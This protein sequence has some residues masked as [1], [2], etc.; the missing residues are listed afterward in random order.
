MVRLSVSVGVVLVLAA[1]G[2]VPSAGDGREKPSGAPPAWSTELALEDR[3]VAAVAG[4]TLVVHDGST[5]RGLSLDGR[6]LWR[7]EV[8]ADSLLGIAGEHIVVHAP[9]EDGVRVI[10][11]G[12]GED[13]WRDSKAGDLAVFGDT[14]YSS[15]CAVGDTCRVT[16]REVSD[17]T[18]RWDVPAARQASVQ[19]DAV[20][21]PY[22]HVPPA[23]RRLALVTMPDGPSGDRWVTPVEA[24]TGKPLSRR[25]EFHTWHAFIAGDVMV[26]TDHDSEPDCGVAM[27]GYDVKTGDQRWS[28]LA[29]SARDTGGDC[30]KFLAPGESGMDAIGDGRT[31]V[32]VTRGGKPQL[33]DL[34]TGR[35]VWT[36]AEPGVPIS[37]QGRF[38]LARDT[39]D[40]GPLRPYDTDSGSRSAVWKAPDPLWDDRL[41][42]AVHREDALVTAKLANRTASGVIRYDLAT[43]DPEATYL[44]SYAGSGDGWLATYQQDESGD[45]WRLHFHTY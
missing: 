34:R 6:D 23:A 27:R 10:D 12:T 5:L 31:V 8:P 19:S 42:V 24:A 39:A 20:G 13:R 36:A 25:A 9:G 21:V 32:A 41:E 33:L 22:P 44:G 37:G 17:G 29:Y 35:T 11:V 7:A 4:R 14:V 15:R 26:V 38:L 2:M 43:G 28:T 40:R 1:C 30:D 16:A 18:V 3:P 45:T